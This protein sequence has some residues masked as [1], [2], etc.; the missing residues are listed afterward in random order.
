M[1]FAIRPSSG[2]REGGRLSR[3][4][5]C[6]RKVAPRWRNRGDNV[7]AFS[8]LG[9]LSPHHHP[10]HTFFTVEGIRATTADSDSSFSFHSIIPVIV[11]S[12]SSSSCGNEIIAHPRHSGN[13]QKGKRKLL[14]L[15]LLAALAP[16]HCMICSICTINASSSC[17]A[18]AF[19]PR[20]G[21]NGSPSYPDLLLA[22]CHYTE[23]NRPPRHRQ[24]TPVSF[25]WRAIGAAEKSHTCTY[26]DFLCHSHPDPERQSYENGN[27]D[28]VS[29][30]AI[31]AFQ[32]PPRFVRFCRM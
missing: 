2:Q 13:W 4:N 15:L 29:I 6:V 28:A 32:N 22:S 5:V 9:L 1:E 7:T 17:L 20:R 31:V 10:P 23:T 25:Q 19:R 30:V 3:T 24:T 16:T 12:S 11:A 14:L 18:P 27:D 21:N 26:A 8:S